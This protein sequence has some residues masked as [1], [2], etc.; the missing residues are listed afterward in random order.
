MYVNLGRIIRI[1]PLLVEE[2]HTTLSMSR[3]RCSCS[4]YLF[5]KNTF[6]LI[7]IEFPKRENL[8]ATTSCDS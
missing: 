5:R 6:I 4:S 2:S 3:S 1:L 8:N 7:F